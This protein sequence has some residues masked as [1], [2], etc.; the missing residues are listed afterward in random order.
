[1]RDATVSSTPDQK[2][3]ESGALETFSVT[4]MCAGTVVGEDSD[5]TGLEVEVVTADDGDAPHP[6][7]EWGIHP[8]TAATAEPDGARR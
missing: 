5:L 4:A 6:V 1:M 7:V 8:P 3:A 2:Y